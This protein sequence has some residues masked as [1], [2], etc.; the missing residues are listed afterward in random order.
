[1]AVCS[2]AIRSRAT[3]RSFSSDSMPSVLANSSSI[4]T[5]P[6][7]SMAF[8]VTSNSACRPASAAF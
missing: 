4:T 5:V 1:M 6:G 8:A 2:R 7:A 3:F